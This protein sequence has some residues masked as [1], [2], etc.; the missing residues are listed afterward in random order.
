MSKLNEHAIM[1]FKAA[2]WLDDSG[3]YIDEMQ[4][5]LCEHVL[6]LLTVF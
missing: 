1:E 3:A 2:G 6:E 4:A 5:M